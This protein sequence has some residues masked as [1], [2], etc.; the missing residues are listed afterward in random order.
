M[1][2]EVVI[3]G[4]G[5]AGL[6]AA[7][8]LAEAG[9][10]PVVVEAGPRLG[11]RASSWIDETTGDPVHIGPHIFLSAYPNLLSLFDRLGTRDRIVWQRD[12]F[13]TIVDGTEAR[14]LRA[15]P[16]PP[17]AHFLP[18]LA[19]IPEIRR[20]DVLSCVP[21]TQLA[22]QL[23]DADIDALDAWNARSFL[24]FMG[25]TERFGDWFWAFVSQ[26]ILNVPLEL[27][28]AGALMRFYAKLI[29]HRDV[30]VGFADG[31]LG[32]CYAP[33]AGA[34]VESRGG[35]VLLRTAVT[36]LAAD[37][38]A[39]T[40]VHLSDGTR[41]DAD[42][43]VAALPPHQLQPLVRPEWRR[44]RPFTDLGAFRPVPYRSVYLWF[45]R[46]LGALPFWARR[47]RRDDLNC[48]FYDLSNIHTGWRDR[49]SVI[50]SN[51]I[52]SHRTDSM[53]HDAIVAATRAELA[54]FLPAARTATLRHA[55]VHDIPMA[56]HAPLP[57]TEALR[58][59]TRT[60][61]PGLVLAGD[62][63]RTG[64]PSSM[65]GACRSGWLAAEQVLADRGRATPLAQGYPPLEG[66]AR[67][68]HAAPR[69]L[70][71]WRT[72]ALL[73]RLGHR[74]PHDR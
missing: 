8:G 26:A 69:A 17:P 22:M 47:Y 59:P 60:P 12:R 31:G 3:V 25:V 53:D 15:A 2:A 66:I 13:C 28:S 19:A 10:R 41:I 4:G 70:T 48:D 34:L 37:R 52:W 46:K 29:G 18:A 38:G 49:P 68:V 44:L 54:E 63:V 42:T 39:I 5:L 45:D 6:T 21:V 72:R 61:I 62:W 16:L 20:R 51:I 67:V 30:H 50:A 35:R 24:A 56:I 64:F 57:G 65:E 55:V 58:P 11:G 43:V 33:Q 9:L 7:V 32:D 73:A 40:G 14:V 71:L 1:R 23:T 27:C 36:A 74:G